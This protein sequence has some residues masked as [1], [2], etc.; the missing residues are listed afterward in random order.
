[1]KKIIYV[2]T[3][4]IDRNK[5][6]S[7]SHLLVIYPISHIYNHPTYVNSKAKSCV[8]ELIVAIKNLLGLKILTELVTAKDG[9]NHYK[10]CPQHYLL[11]P[12]VCVPSY[13]G[14]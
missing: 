12:D 3:D 1:M 10:E 9:H 14:L 6:N 4:K 7:D 11:Y 2:I 5:Y 13:A 8:D